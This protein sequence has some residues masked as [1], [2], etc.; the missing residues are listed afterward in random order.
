M[1]RSWI[2]EFLEPEVRKQHGFP[3]NGL[4][5]HPV[6]SNRIKSLFQL[7]IFLVRWLTFVT[8]TKSANFLRNAG[9]NCFTWISEKSLKSRMRTIPLV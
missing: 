9:V 5:K 8:C 7:F 4:G 3:L 2:Q 1:A 6:E